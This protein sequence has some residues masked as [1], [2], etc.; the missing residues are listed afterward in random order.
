MI[1]TF[2]HLFIC[3]GTNRDGAPVCGALLTE[4]GNAAQME[5]P[6]GMC[7]A[8][9][10]I[11]PRAECFQCVYPAVD[12]RPEDKHSGALMLKTHKNC[13]QC[14]SALIACDIDIGML[15]PP[16]FP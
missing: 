14:N 12:P 10:N 16:P 11:H 5:L 1:F 7:G 6:F 15:F 13:E 9:T 2:V 8:K 3:I 4:N